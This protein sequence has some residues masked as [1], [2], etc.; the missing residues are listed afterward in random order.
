MGWWTKAAAGMLVLAAGCSGSIV[1]PGAGSPSGG[2]RPGDPG[3]V[4]PGLPGASPGTTAPATPADPNAAGPLLLRRLTIREYNNTVRDLLGDGSGPASQFP[5]DR[6]ETF[7]FRR[8]GPVAVQDATLLRTAAETLATAAARKLAPLLPCDPAAVGE[9]PCTRQ[10]VDRF[11]LRAFRRPLASAEADRLM[12]LY[13]AGR[14]SLGLGFADAIGLVIEGILQSPAFLYHAE[15]QNEA[16]VREGVV[17]RLGPYQTASRLSYFLWGSMPDADLLTA[18]AAG[19]LGTADE[20]QAQ[21][22]RMLADVRA[23]DTVAA[24]F[25]EWLALD[26]LDQTAKDPKAYP[27]YDDALRAAM[28][29]ETTAF[30]RDV[31]F[32]GDGRWGTLLGAPYSF[33][34]QALGGLYGVAMSGTGLQRADLDPRQR[35]GFLTEASF[36]TLTGSV[37]GSH[38]VRRGKAVFE[39][40]LCGELPPPPANVPPAKPAS[41]GGTTRERFVEH[42][43]NDCARA[44]HGLIDPIGFAFESYDGIGRYRTTDNGKPVDATGWVTLDGR[45]QTFDGALA[46]GQLLAGS[47]EARRCFATQWIRFALVRNEQEADR[48]SVQ[49]AAAGFGRTEATVRDLLVAVTAS[50]SFRYRSPSPGETP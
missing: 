30:V 39:K 50:R 18:A 15:G 48:A 23:R 35:G 43:S 6:D 27:Q 7:P 9:Q 24:F 34:N 3:N 19:H 33:V 10:F 22:R 14:T 4:A 8:S 47:D 11:G 42:D 49:A 21:A 20:V 25:S 26:Q 29:G 12:A 36:L 38:P 31:V 28:I 32:A 13:T 40:L 41:A 46:L 17:L 1:D 2:T 44:C 5:S 16:A 45:K 37:D